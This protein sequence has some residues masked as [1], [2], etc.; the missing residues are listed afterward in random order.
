METNTRKI[1][2]HIRIW[3]YDLS[4]YI[5]IS[6]LFIMIQNV[7]NA[8]FLEWKVNQSDPKPTNFDYL[9]NNSFGNI[10]AINVDSCPIKHL[11]H[12]VVGV[13]IIHPRRGAIQISLTSP[14]GTDSMLL[15]SRKKDYVSIIIIVITYYTSVSAQATVA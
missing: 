5:I 14:M 13:K 15:G 8:T 3:R 12:V 6:T 4:I 9:E 10:S 11:E 1:E 7:S 2:L